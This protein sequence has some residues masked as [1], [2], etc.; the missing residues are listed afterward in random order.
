MMW[1]PSIYP[2]P[3]AYDGRRFLRLRQS[4]DTGTA[5]APSSLEHI[6]FGMGK[7]LC[8]RRFF[9]SNE[10][11]IALAKILLTYDVKIPEGFE[12]KIVE[13]GFEMLSD[14]AAKLDVRKRLGL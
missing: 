14:P 10:V 5:L 11:K 9:V 3:Y 12:P 6:A 7:A 13:I 8:P 1:D 4:G 2:N